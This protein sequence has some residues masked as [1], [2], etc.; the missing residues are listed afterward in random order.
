MTQKLKVIPG[1][2][3]PTELETELH[4]LAEMKRTVN[5]KTEYIGF[6]RNN[7]QLVKIKTKAEKV[8]EEEQKL[9]TKLGIFAEQAEID[10]M[11]KEINKKTT[12]LGQKIEASCW[13]PDS[14]TKGKK[15]AVATTNG[16][17]R[18][19]RGKRTERKVVPSIFYEKYPFLMEKF[20]QDGKVKIPLNVVETELG[21]NDI[22]NV[23]DITVTY[24]FE[25]S[26]PEDDMKKMEGK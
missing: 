11:N 26:T 18:L 7:E 23:C 4:V 1:N 5:E 17:I 3:L 15:D 16:N 21:T 2:K 9:M 24:T 20:V 6:L 14:F 10:E 22:A 8:I 13:G 12:E 19:L 25:L